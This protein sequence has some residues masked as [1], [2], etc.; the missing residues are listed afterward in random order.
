MSL[1]IKEIEK[2]IRTIH[3]LRKMYAALVVYIF[4][5]MYWEI[6]IMKLYKQPL[7]SSNC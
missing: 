4:S 2:K 5:F 6:F 3:M 7:L 1:E